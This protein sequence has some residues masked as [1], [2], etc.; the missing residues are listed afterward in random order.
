MIELTFTNSA[1]TSVG[2]Q[3]VRNVQWTST[4]AEEVFVDAIT[5]VGKRQ[6]QITVKG[7]L[8]HTIFNTARTA[9]ETLETNLRA[10]GTGTLTYTGASDFSDVRF[11][12]LEFEEY[13]G[14]PLAEFTIKF[15]TDE[16]NIHA[17]KNSKIGSLLLTAANGFEEPT[18]T[19]TIGVQ[20]DDEQLNNLTRRS[21][22]ISGDI[23][24][25]TLDEVMSTQVDLVA[26]VE[27]K[28]T[29]VITLSSTATTPGA[30]TVRPRNLRFG[31]PK[32]KDEKTARSYIFECTTHDDYTKEP[33]TLGEV[34]QSFAGISL[35][36]VTGVDHNTDREIN[37]TGPSYILTDET[38]EITGKKYFTGWTAYAAFRDLFTPIPVNTY[39]FASTSGNQL[40]LVDINVG[41]MERDGNSVADN[42][43]R[44]SAGISLSFEWV[45]SIQDS[46][47]EFSTSHFG[48]TWYK[49]ENVSFGVTIDDKG[50]VSSRSV[51]VSGSVQGLTI[52][53]NL[54]AK[55]GTKVDF[56]GTFND[57]YVSGVSVNGIETVNIDSS[58]V[59][60]ISV[61]VTAAQLNT[62]GQAFHFLAG[63]FDFA[64]AGGTGTVYATEV[65]N[66]DKVTNRTKSFANRWDTSTQKFIVT[67][68]NFSVSGEVFSN[69]ANN[70]PADKNKFIELFNKIDS[71]LNAVKSEKEATSHA[72]PATLLPTN[73][74]IHFFLTNINVGGWDPF[75]DEAT[76]VRRWKQSLSLSATAV[77]DLAGSS[78]TQPDSVETRSENIVQ[79]API[80]KQI[81]ILNFGTVFKRIGTTPETLTVTYQIRWKNA[82]LYRQANLSGLNFGKDL[83]AAGSWRGASKNNKTK[84]DEGNSGLTNR[85]IVVYTANDKMT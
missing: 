12:S 28:N 38:L 32:V 47:F 8:N 27:N 13:R 33:Y 49:V 85:H 59:D 81:Q 65:L 18:V 11:T 40:E 6:R 45:K 66:F 70:E 42:A 72:T 22:I 14:N 55:I 26:E 77:F 35:D 7:F 51:S 39:L 31:S 76:G 16:D 24:G 79:E 3:H 67:S 34:V 78:E 5:R 80:Y 58:E 19:D 63:V 41:K 54:K 25:A 56:D 2:L 62:A 30:Y 68:I 57:M 74:N 9:Q 83:V 43:K 17:H 48:I 4:T 36:V 84:D 37:D 1:G 10:V 82:E 53:N 20:G 64:K 60:I 23:V 75:I 50:N 61:S 71:L 52:F 15:I 73:P 69:D 46:V 29:V 44:Y 21:F